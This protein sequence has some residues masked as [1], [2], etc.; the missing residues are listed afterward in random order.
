MSATA[1]AWRRPRAVVFVAAAAV[2]L[3][4]AIGLTSPAV[5]HEPNTLKY[6]VTVLGPAVVAG[7]ALARQPLRLLVG[8]AI[9]VA[10][11]DFVAT[12]A[13]IQVTPLLAVLLLAAILAAVTARPGPAGLLGFATVAAVLLLIPAIVSGDSRASYAVWLAETVLLGWLAFN[14]ARTPGGT[15]FVLMAITLSAFVE[16]VLAVYEYESGHQ[17][18]L[19]NNSA[20]STASASYFFEYGNVTRSSG[21]MPDP[22]ALG[23]VLALSCPLIVCLAVAY[24]QLWV[25][26]ALI[27]IGG[28][29]LVGL[30]LSYSRIGWVA[31]VV[32]LVVCLVLLPPRNR[33]ATAV[34]TAAILAAMLPVAVSLGG[35]NL[36]RRLDSLLHPTKTASSYTGTARGDLLRIRLWHAA[37]ATA[38]DNPVTGTGFGRLTPQ[39]ERHGVS[40]PSAAHAQNWYLQILGEA[41][42]LGGLALLLL[43]LAATRDLAVAFRRQRVWVAGSAGAFVATL[44]TWLT[45]ISPRYVQVSGVI[46]AL[47]GVICAQAVAEREDAVAAPGRERASQEALP[48]IL[49]SPSPDAEAVLTRLGVPFLV[50]HEVESDGLSGARRA[51]LATTVELAKW[52]ARQKL[53]ASS[54]PGRDETVLGI[55][56]LVLGARGRVQPVPQNEEQARTLLRDARGTVQHVV[57]AVALGWPGGMLQ[58]ADTAAVELRELTDAEIDAYV[59]TGEWRGRRSGYAID[60]AGANLVSSID[61]AHETALGLPLR[62][63]FDIYP[64]LFER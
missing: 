55:H 9:L 61:G 12:F 57:S 48:L 11:I 41:G 60:G 28:V 8:L 24:R 33:L 14:V 15:R 50:R 46:A 13:G 39:L 4:S 47:L 18:N 30:A 22:I 40:V 25:R 20:V 26:L 31:A 1:F 27:G 23:N 36:H 5:F 17:L 52:K 44:V 58:A 38:E 7:L 63:L 29:T 53:F 51:S 16:A 54:A 56:S 21:A 62:A 32:G 49:A 6:V 2:C 3:V 64:R 34:A 43:I 35:S 59:A 42:A 19:Y 45:D 10:P 37:L